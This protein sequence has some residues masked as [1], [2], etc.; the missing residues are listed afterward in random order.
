RQSE[1]GA[2]AKAAANRDPAAHLPSEAAADGEP[3]P[4]ARFGLPGAR[5]DLL[6]LVE[7][8]LDVCRGDAAAG[9]RHGDLDHGV[10]SRRADADG[11]GFGELGLIVHEVDQDAPELAF[12]LGK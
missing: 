8:P 12:V 4:D 2:L 7:D 11:A 9:I 10:P 5:L 3:E 6:A 1:H